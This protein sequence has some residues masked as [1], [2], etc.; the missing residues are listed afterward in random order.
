MAP[1]IEVEQDAWSVARLRTLVAAGSLA[2]I[3]CGQVEQGPAGVN[4]VGA[5]EP[6]EVVVIELEVAAPEGSDAEPRVQLA[7]RG[8]DGA[9]SPLPGEYLSALDFRSGVAAV[10]ASRELHIVRDEGSQSVLARQVDG[11]PTRASDGSL[12]YAARFGQTVEIH[13]LTTQ[14]ED[15]RLASFRGSATRLAPQGDQTVAFVGSVNG[16]VAGLW[17]A[18]PRGARC[19]TN[20]ELRTGQPWGDAY[21]PP[22]GEA[23]TIR[24]GDSSIEWQTAEGTWES[25]PLRQEGQ[26]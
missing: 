26:Q 14:G 3:A 13:W 18:D 5:D 19:I 24:L 17:I 7:R 16:G 11:L 22:P 15:H 2:A 21:R 6:G 23:S 12:V 1:R 9:L 4:T 20:C 25:A 10:T 8:S